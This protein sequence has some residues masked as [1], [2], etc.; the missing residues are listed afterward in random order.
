[1]SHEI[2]ELSLRGFKKKA[3]L[4]SRNFSGASCFLVIFKDETNSTVIRNQTYYVDFVPSPLKPQ[5]I[6]N[7]HQTE[8]I[9]VY[10]TARKPVQD[11]AF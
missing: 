7:I 3:T 1:M 5:I 4:P 11:L 8:C 6:P 10:R 9:P 2:A